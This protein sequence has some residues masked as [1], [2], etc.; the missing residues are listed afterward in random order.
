MFNIDFVNLIIKNTKTIY[1][2]SSLIYSLSFNP[3]GNMLAL[4][5]VKDD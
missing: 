3:N 4:N 2:S 1:K 5:T